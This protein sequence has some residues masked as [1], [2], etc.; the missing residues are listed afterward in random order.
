[1]EK[2]F[3]TDLNIKE[4]PKPVATLPP[5]RYLRVEDAPLPKNFQAHYEPLPKVVNIGMILRNI[6]ATR[7]FRKS[8]EE[9][10]EK[11]A[12]QRDNE[13]GKKGGSASSS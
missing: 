1:M 2:A 12:L 4:E 11:I 6:A 7:P 8:V 9:M 3:L 13:R 10:K 5:G